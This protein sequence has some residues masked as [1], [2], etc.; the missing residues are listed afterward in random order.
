MNRVL[1][2]WLATLMIFVGAVLVWTVV[3][4]RAPES[5][6]MQVVDD[7]A[8]VESGRPKLTEFEL[9]DQTGK[10]VNS[11]ELD[12][13]VWAGSFFF[14]SC[15]STCYN[16]N[17]KLQQ[18]HAKYADQGLRLISITCDPGKDT[19]AALAGYASR[20]NADP[21]RWKF[22]TPVDG[23][24]QYISRVANDYFG[25]PVGPET[26]TDRVMLFDRKGNM[27]GAYSV[28]NAQQF[29]ELD[30]QIAAALAGHAAQDGNESS[31]ND[32]ADAPESGEGRHDPVTTAARHSAS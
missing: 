4:N 2:F 27:L 22:L 15:P 29:R 13:E 17:I 6:S 21:H 16:Q 18:L 3:R 19:P 10:R 26:H 25:L 5:G 30:E 28:L 31:I 7:T 24:M 14:A 8:S 9:L 20:F 23:D 11:H 32:S 1:M 12:G